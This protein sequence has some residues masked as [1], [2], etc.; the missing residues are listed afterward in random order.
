MKIGGYGV[1]LTTIVLAI[2]I[3][4]NLFINSL[5]SS[6]T[7]Y[8]TTSFGLYEVSAE[9]EKLLKS[10]SDDVTVYLIAES[11]TEDT[12]IKELVGRY[13]SINANI[14]FKIVDPA[15]QPTFV[16]QYTDEQLS[17]NSVIVVNNDN[18]RVKCIDYNEIY[19][20]TYTDEEIYYYYY[21]G[22]E[23]TG[24]SSF[25]GEREITS[26]IDF[27]TAVKLPKIYITSGSGETAIGDTLKQYIK[28]E[29]VQTESLDLKSATKIPADAD[30]VLLNLPT[31]DLEKA[32]A[33]VL[34]SYINQG[35][36]V[37]L[38]TEFTGTEPDKFANL[39][40]LCGEY[41]L[42]RNE[43][44]LLE[45]DAN[46]YASSTPYYV[47]PNYSQNSTSALI[48]S[49]LPDNSPIIFRYAHGISVSESLGADVAV[50]PL[51]TSTDSAYLKVEINENSTAAKEEGDIS[52]AFLYAAIGEKITGTAKNGKLVWFSSADIISEDLAAYANIDYFMA[53]LTEICE[54]EASVA[55]ATKPMQ[56]EALNTNEAG[57][58]IWGA[59][60]IVVTPAA[61]LIYGFT[62][63]YGRR[64]R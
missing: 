50:T 10:I 12:V 54:K 9:S 60:L 45:G 18:G 56:V 28:S 36:C 1:I 16:S 15:I 39:N 43:G 20:V 31:S 52:G 17:S 61:I 14:K 26:A 7:K 62:V 6:I 40:A 55:I 37:I 29:N 3:A 25:A 59:L 44:L 34:K 41:G 57:A 2:A 22:I 47:L 4:A 23:P 46:N 38:V 30:V 58:N 24:T 21:Y 49:K 32:N 51:L 33:E 27:V 53:L 35:G 48:S 42:I 64:K 5:P 13:S 8:D 19:E 11:K 63:W